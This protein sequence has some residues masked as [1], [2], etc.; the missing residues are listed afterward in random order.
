MTQAKFIELCESLSIAPSIALE[1][2]ALCE[3]LQS[4][5]DDTVVRILNEE[6]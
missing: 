5:D 2:D 4:R 6:F 1:S 3:A